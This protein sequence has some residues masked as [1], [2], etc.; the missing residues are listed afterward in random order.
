MTAALPQPLHQFCKRIKKCVETVGSH[1]TERFGDERIRVHDL[2]HFSAS[3][4]PQNPGSYGLHYPEL[5]PWLPGSRLGRFERRTTLKSCT[6]GQN[7]VNT[8]ALFPT[9]NVSFRAQIEG[10]ALVLFI[11]EMVR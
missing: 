5:I 4:D 11:S 1:L 3:L 10:N 2:W 9:A 8:L 7:F 6:L